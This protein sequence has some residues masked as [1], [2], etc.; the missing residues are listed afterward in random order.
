MKILFY[1]SWSSAIVAVLVSL[2]LY[3]FHIIPYVAYSIT[4]V[5]S[6][7]QLIVIFII[8]KQKQSNEAKEKLL[9]IIKEKEQKIE[10]QP[11]KVGPAWELARTKLEA[12]FDRNLDQINAI[13]WI[14]VVIMIVGF[15][16]ILYGITRSLEKP[17]LITISYV[18]S[19]A[20][21]ITEFIGTTLM[22]IYRSTLKQATSYMATLERINSVG[23]AVQILDSIPDGNDQ[24]KNTTRAEIAK[25]LLSTGKKLD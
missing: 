9:E 2:L 16:F 15:G 4:N 18:A 5:I 1:V 19:I 14:S 25:V 22:A 17:E 10:K 24:L 7:A 6:F 21:I 3:E 13:F 23:M 20:G 12:Y 8:I 11:E